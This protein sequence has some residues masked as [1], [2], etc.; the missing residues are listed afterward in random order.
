MNKSE[1][2]EYEKA[3]ADFFDRECI[4]CLS[5][6][7]SVYNEGCIEPHFSWQPCDCCNRPLGGNRTDC[8]AY[9]PITEEIQDGYSICDDCMHYA[10]Y[11]QL[12]DTTMDMMEG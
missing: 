1:Y 8:N 7:T 4:N 6:D 10:E 9:N 11:G 3:V 5:Y 12:D 2:A